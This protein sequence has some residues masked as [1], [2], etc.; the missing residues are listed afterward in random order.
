MQHH[1]L[2]FEEIVAHYEQD[3]FN[4]SYSLTGKQEHAE[5]ITQDV[6]VRVFRYIHLFRG[7]SSFKTWLFTITRN[8]TQDF[9]RKQLDTRIIL[10]HDLQHHECSPSA[11]SDYF[12]Y[13][14]ESEMCDLVLALPP[15]FQEVLLLDV[16]YDRSMLEIASLLNISIGTVKSRLYRA[17]S[18][19]SKLLIGGNAN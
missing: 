11:E 14:H 2:P 15:M 16:K 5:E 3:I 8:V 4:Y 6:F 10:T 13:R 19:I 17:R 12:E 1:P 7:D 9:K 18:K